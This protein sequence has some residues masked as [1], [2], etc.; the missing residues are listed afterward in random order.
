MEDEY[1]TTL[2][3]S[4]KIVGGRK[5]KS[6]FLWLYEVLS[7]RCEFQTNRK[8]R[9]EKLFIKQPKECASFPLDNSNETK[10]H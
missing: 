2:R 6:S 5:F 4:Y 7:V 9:S 8:T 10:F 3:Y 1:T